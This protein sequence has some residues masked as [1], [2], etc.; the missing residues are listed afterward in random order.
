MRFLFVVDRFYP[1]VSANTVCCDNLLKQF[2]S[3]GHQVDV[4]TIKKNFGD[5]DIDDYD[6]SS[7]FRLDTYHFY[8]TKKLKKDNWLKIPAFIRKIIGF[9]YSVK[10]KF[11]PYA[12]KGYLDTVNVNKLYKT[13]S[14]VATEPYDGMLSFTEPFALQ[15]ICKKLMK[16]GIAKKWCTY[17][18]DA[19]EFNA[20]H[21]KVKFKK[22]VKIANAMFK[23]NAKIF[24]VDGV[25]YESDLKGYVPSYKEKVIYTHQPM[26]TNKGVETVNNGSEVKIVY[27][28]LFYA[29]IRRPNEMLEVLSNLPKGYQIDIYGDGC[30]DIVNE[31]SK[32]FT[33]AKLNRN[34]RISHA[35]CLTKI[36][37]SNIL[38]NL[39]NKG[40]KQLPSKVIEYI[41]FGKPIINF[42]FDQDDISLSIFNKYPL[43]YNFNLSNYTQ[44]DINEC[45]KFCEDNKFVQ[46]TYK[47]AT[48]NL[49]DF[50][51]EN[52][53]NMVLKEF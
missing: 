28:G 3:L 51:I 13:I 22:R 27:A 19:F 30:E 50:K 16:K 1:D 5:N 31:K 4:L 42:Y 48:K 26:L 39:G 41:G 53:A 12:L 23:D 40:S 7:V 37:Q 38:I 35:E 44:Q 25:F 52:L 20:F 34:G 24:A 21:K 11:N 17:M 2:K 32:L 14:I 15:P 18:L 33:K 46:L 45:L 8:W 10:A 6:G 9:C 36:A 29:D 47:Q 49:Q 43:V